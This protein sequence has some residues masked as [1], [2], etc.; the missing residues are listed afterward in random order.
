MAKP[1]K[2]WQLLLV[3]DDGRIVPFKR[4]KGIVTTLAV[5]MVILALACAGLG[6]QLTAEK[7]RHRNTRERLADANRQLDHYKGEVEMITAELVLAQV[8]M[9]KAGLPV[10]RRHERIPQPV[11][12]KRADDET[13]AGAESAEETTETAPAA[14]KEIAAADTPPEPSAEQTAA[15]AA[16]T[17][18]AGAGAQAASQVQPVVALGDLVMTHD[19]EKKV[20]SARFRV[21]N[22]DPGPGKVAGQCVV[23]LQNDDLETDTWMALPKVVLEE[24]IPDGQGGRA[25]KISR[26]VDME[27]MV[28]VESD[29]SVFDVARV[30]V[31]EPSGAVIVQQDYPITLPPPTAA[32]TQPADTAE[33][34]TEAAA[35][36]ETEKPVVALGEL[37]MTFDAATKVLLAQF[38][39]SN[40]GN[41]SEP[42][43]GRCVVVLKSG[44]D[45][46]K[47]WLA[48]PQVRLVDG[49][50]EGTRGQAFRIARFRD[51]NIKS[52]EVN[53]PSVYKSA[54]VYVF[55]TSGAKLLERTF[56]IDLPAPLQ[57]P[58]P[59]SEP[60]AAP[61]AVPG[62]PATPADDTPSAPTTPQEPP[63]AEEAP[64]AVDA[65]Q[66]EA[67][68]ATDT[69][70]DAPPVP[71]VAPSDDPS[72]I[73]GVAP[74]SQ[75]D[76]RSRF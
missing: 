3:A 30:Y 76:T 67:A 14:E 6:W 31:F 51:M 65:A 25:F 21:Q 23:V 29:P 72:L 2:R 16:D 45:D 53:D 28:P 35:A 10:T 15:T 26:F 48:M 40:N 1:E 17:D 50:P 66:P 44:Q 36:A 63:P 54:V 42:V 9:E 68:P 75:E 5:L 4:I 19:T 73:E 37:E 18:R 46:P 24:G 22:N 62:T 61:A 43:A 38:R 20:L 69:A 58:E 11:D 70:S 47:T 56:S 71:V 34:S 52:R 64:G 33:P 27:I 41:R 74:Q 49:E 55:D 7:V 32:Q 13:A 39:V 8:R 12:L 57:Q 60:Q 59:A